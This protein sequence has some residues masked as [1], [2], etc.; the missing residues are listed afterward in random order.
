M[1]MYMYM[2]TYMYMYMYMYMYCETQHFWYLMPVLKF[3][4]PFIFC[5][6]ILDFCKDKR[7]ICFDSVWHW[8]CVYCC[9]KTFCKF[10]IVVIKKGLKFIIIIFLC[11]KRDAQ[12][13]AVTKGRGPRIFPGYYKSEPRLLWYKI[14]QNE[15]IGKR[16]MHQISYELKN[17]PIVLFIF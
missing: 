8:R 2:Y 17:K 14:A 3:L 9:F 6:S 12:F 1:Y 15:N 16:K 4:F 13:R 10:L 5:F 11:W 7:W